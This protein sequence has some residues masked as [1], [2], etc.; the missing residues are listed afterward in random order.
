M[1]ELSGQVCAFQD[2]GDSLF[3]EL[4]LLTIIARNF[5]IQLLLNPAYFTQ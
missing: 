3:E 1:N 4:D 2:V 5:R